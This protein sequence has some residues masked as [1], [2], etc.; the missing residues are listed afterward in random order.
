MKH[1][2]QCL[3]L[4]ERFLRL[5]WCFLNLSPQ[6]VLFSSENLYW[7]IFQVHRVSLPSSHVSYGAHLVYL[8]I[9]LQLLYFLALELLFDLKLLFSS[10][11]SFYLFTLST[12]FF[13]FLNTYSC[14]S[15]TYLYYFLAFENLLTYSTS[16][17]TLSQFP[18]AASLPRPPCPPTSDMG[19]LPCFFACIVI[20]CWKPDVVYNTLRQL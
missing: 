15:R 14:N 7:Y 13:T 11:F 1:V 3:I 19:H 20:F 6:A 2:L 17:S 4:L 18:V 10:M 9:F 16:R 8:N 12:F 5:C